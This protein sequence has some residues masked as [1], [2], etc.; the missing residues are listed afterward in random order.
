[1]KS[2]NVRLA[3]TRRCFLLYPSM[4]HDRGNIMV[5]VHKLSNSD[6]DD[7]LFEPFPETDLW[8]SWM[9]V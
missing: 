6:D 1:M 7:A 5:W 4:T 3:K 9:G 8:G 2:V